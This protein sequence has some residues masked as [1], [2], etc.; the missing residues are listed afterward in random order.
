VPA[1]RLAEQQ[2]ALGA[3]PYLYLFA[4]KTKAFG[5][6]LGACHALEIP[7]VFDNL[8]KPGVE[9]FTGASKTRKAV[10]TPMHQAWVAFARTGDPNH[11]G[12]PEWPSYDTDRRATMR[13]D[14][15]S[16]VVLDPAGDERA[17]WA[18]AATT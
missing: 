17:L 14:R 5:G 15:R 6:R 1:V 16:Q 4:W 3:T 10:A 11:P 7:F 12:L 13:F 9:L 2:A 18:G 8:R